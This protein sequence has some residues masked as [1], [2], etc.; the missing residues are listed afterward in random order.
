VYNIQHEQYPLAPR[1]VPGIE[2]AVF[3]SV[4]ALRAA[5]WIAK[6]FDLDF[7]SVLDR[8]LVSI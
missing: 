8:W 4:W 3:A 5:M 6:D 2:T 1:P 7:E